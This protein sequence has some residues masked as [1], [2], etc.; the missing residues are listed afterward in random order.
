MTTDKDKNNAGVA[1]VTVE[2]KLVALYSLQTI[3]SKTDSI[4]R[5]C[6]ELP[7]EVQDLEDELVGLETRISKIKDEITR[8]ESDVARKKNDIINAQQLIKK[9]EAQQMQVRNNR[10]YDS[11]AK[12]VEFQHLDI[13]LSEKK[14]KEFE[15]QLVTKK[16]NLTE[17]IN[18]H[19]DRQKD[20]E[21]KKA[22]LDSIIEDTKKDEEALQADRKQYEDKIEER[23]L[24]AYNRIRGGAKNGLA[25]VPVRRDACGGCFN[26]I[27]PQRQLDVASRKKIIVCE[28]CG[29]IFIDDE[30]A[31]QVADSIK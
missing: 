12:E 28:Y 22:E 9:Y 8:L 21:R 6:G 19:D 13:N 4:R 26:K 17:S 11:I 18:R 24:N 31:Q 1:E 16:N 20:L 29:R 25:V 5:L 23:L 2:E 15:N 14:I 7:L 10:E 3:D 30:L 27:P